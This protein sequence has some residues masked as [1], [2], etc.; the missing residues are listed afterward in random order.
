MFK[1]NILSSFSSI[2]FRFFSFYISCVLI[3]TIPRPNQ[4][5]QFQVSWLCRVYS[6]AK[7]CK[8]DST[9]KKDLLNV[10]IFFNYFLISTSKF[11]IRLHVSN[12]LWFVPITSIVFSIRS[13]LMKMLIVG[14]ISISGNSKTI[15]FAVVF[16][17]AL[18]KHRSCFCCLVKVFTGSESIWCWRRCGRANESLFKMV[19]WFTEFVGFRNSLQK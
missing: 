8:V 13:R 14:S 4:G 12:C 19:L 11:I 2:D 16:K 7:H 9:T 10:K 5:Q 3:S 15:I 6:S 1:T 18:T 17:L